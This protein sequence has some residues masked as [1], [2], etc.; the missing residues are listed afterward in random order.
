MRLYN[1]VTLPPTSGNVNSRVEIQ[2]PVQ[3]DIPNGGEVVCTLGHLDHS[4]NDNLH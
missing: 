3:Y 1:Q 2:L 4:P